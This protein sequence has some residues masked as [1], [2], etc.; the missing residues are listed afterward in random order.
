MVAP[1]Q[2]KTLSSGFQ[3]T[4]SNALS[5]KLQ[6]F[7]PLILGTGLGMEQLW[8]H[9]QPKQALA[10]SDGELELRYE[11]LMRRF[12]HIVWT[13]GLSFQE[14]EKMKQLLLNLD[15]LANR[16][17]YRLLKSLEVSQAS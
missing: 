16:D 1:S 10:R 11:A 4:L 5:A 12:D 7:G 6:A 15:V 2:Q 3:T 17:E 13:S 9:F 8:H 14:C